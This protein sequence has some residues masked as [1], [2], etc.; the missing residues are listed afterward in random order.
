MMVNKKNKLK[1]IFKVLN[2]VEDIVLI[3]LVIGMLSTILIQIIGRVVGK[4]IPWTE[5][6]SRYLF[7]WMMFIALAS[8]FNRVES[9][10]VVMFVENLP[11][12]LKVI[13]PIIYGIFV[14]FIFIF[15]IIYG[16]EVVKQQIM[17]NETG[18]AIKLPMYLVGLCQ[19]VAGILGLMGVFQSFIEYPE[20]IKLVEEKSH[21]LENEKE[22]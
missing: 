1:K 13:V 15:M 9:S 2:K 16:G 21:E 20:K 14:T 7:L 11:K 10:R 12:S 5:E 18:T 22:D 8:G 3:I 4:P 6:V 17:L 19:P